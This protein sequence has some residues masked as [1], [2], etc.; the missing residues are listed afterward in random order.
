M[1]RSYGRWEYS[2]ED[3]LCKSVI[4]YLSNQNDLTTVEFSH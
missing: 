3:S 4:E 2:V 1:L